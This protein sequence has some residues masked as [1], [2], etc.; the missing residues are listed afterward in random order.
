MYIRDKYKDKLGTKRILDFRADILGDSDKF[1]Q[2]RGKD[3]LIIYTDGGDQAD[4]DGGIVFDPALNT[5]V[6]IFDFLHFINITVPI[7]I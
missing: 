3:R 5:K 2:S 6:L 1:L 7:H 4:K